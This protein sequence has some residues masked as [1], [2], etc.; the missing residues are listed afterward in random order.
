MYCPVYPPSTTVS[1]TARPS[2]LG[3]TDAITA[4]GFYNLWRHMSRD[5]W[6]HTMQVLCP[7]ISSLMAVTWDDD[8]VHLLLYSVVAVVVVVGRRWST[9]WRAAATASRRRAADTGTITCLSLVARSRRRAARKTSAPSDSRQI[10]DP[11]HS[12]AVI[13][14]S[15]TSDVISDV[16]SDVVAVARGPEVTSA[17][18]S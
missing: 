7:V 2:S 13:T 3:S 11:T 14:S 10:A 4:D 17:A 15:A 6:R 5:V 12:D 1:I 16:T 18:A 8:D 9:F